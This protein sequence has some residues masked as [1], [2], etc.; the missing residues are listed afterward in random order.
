MTIGHNTVKSEL[1][2]SFVERLERIDALKKDLS[3][4]EKGIFA[5]AAI[6][7]LDK[8]G[9]NYVR[10]ARRMKPHDRMDAET[11]R[12]QYMHAAGMADEL[13]L[14]RQMESLV[15][16]GASRDQVIHAFL[17]LVPTN[18]EVIVK[19]GGKPVRL[20]RDKDGNP[21]VEDYA[22]PEF[23]PTEAHRPAFTPAPKKDVPECTAEEAEAL[24]EKAGY[25][26]RA[27]IENPFPFDDARRPRWDLGWRRGAGSDG[28]GPKR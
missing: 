15:N 24:G 23:K 9:I 20:F 3:N 8:A 21:Q 14:F 22:E 7:G 6:E 25:D 19:M 5:E 17:Q 18:G 28:M 27:V 2:M 26:N 10:K 1:V 13:P 12:D 4:D 16:D 11:V